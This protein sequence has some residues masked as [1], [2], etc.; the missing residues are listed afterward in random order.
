MS[1]SIG[2]PSGNRIQD[3]QEE[4]VFSIISGLGI[5]TLFIVLGTEARS[6][7]LRQQARLWATLNPRLAIAA[8]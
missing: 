6:D 2:H 7:K 4:N 8:Y 1:E 5:P 3:H